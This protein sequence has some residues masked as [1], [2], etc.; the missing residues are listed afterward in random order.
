MTVSKV[1]TH[2]KSKYFNGPLCGA[3]S[4]KITSNEKSVN[5]KRCKQKIK[6]DRKR[7]ENIGV[8]RGHYLGWRSG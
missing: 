1:I 3:S 5:C 2:L 7:N 8:Y 6:S 4:K